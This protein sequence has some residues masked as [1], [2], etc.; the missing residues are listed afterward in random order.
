MSDPSRDPLIELDDVTFGYPGGEPLIEHASLSLERGGFLVLTGSSGAGKSSL[1][2]LLVRLEAQR[3]GAIRYLGQPIEAVPASRL[4]T[5]LLSIGQTPVMTEGSVR[6]NLLLPFSFA[7]NAPR[8]RPT[9]ASL[10]QGLD[11]VRL[12]DVSLDDEARSLSVGQRQRLAL[13]RGLLM[14]P[15]ALLLDEP[16]S[17]LDADS[18]LVVTETLGALHRDQGITVIMV[19]HRD[20]VPRGVSAQRYELADRRIQPVEEGVPS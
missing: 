9:D 16:T 13:V 1:L 5:R 12:G 20:P 15:E 7:A 8:S 3:S 10:R 18:A 11:E 6:A 2:R 17:A 19:S 4:R 14:E